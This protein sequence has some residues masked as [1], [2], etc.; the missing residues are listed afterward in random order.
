MTSNSILHSFKRWSLKSTIVNAHQEAAQ[1]NRIGVQPGEEKALGR[2]YSSLPVLKK[3]Y[4]KMGRDSVRNSNDRTSD[5]SFELTESRFKLDNRKKYFT[6]RMVRC[7]NVL[8]KEVVDA[9]SLDAFKGI[10]WSL[11]SLPIQTSLWFYDFLIYN[12]RCSRTLQQFCNKLRSFWCHLPANSSTRP[13]EIITIFP[14]PLTSTCVMWTSVS[15]YAQPHAD[16]D[17]RKG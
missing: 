6:Q 16:R 5:I 8:L 12:I 2:P 1:G 14:L 17:I 11:R 3:A 9:P 10:K 13:A 15:N 7:W 4:R